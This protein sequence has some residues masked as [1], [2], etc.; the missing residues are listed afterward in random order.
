MA[1]KTT[2]SNLPKIQNTQEL[3]QKT[4]RLQEIQT[5]LERL[6]AMPLVNELLDIKA[7]IG[8]LFEKPKRIRRTKAQI[9]ADRARIK[10]QD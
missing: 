3:L 2:L 5:Q 6:N 10:A 7:Q 9:E 8:T 1:N 4:Q